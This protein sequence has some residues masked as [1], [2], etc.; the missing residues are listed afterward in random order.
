MTDRLMETK[1]IL[2]QLDQLK[3]EI[4]PL[5]RRAT[6]LYALLQVCKENQCSKY[7]DAQWLC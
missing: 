5:A 7:E 6:M 1:D 4:F 2:H 3:E